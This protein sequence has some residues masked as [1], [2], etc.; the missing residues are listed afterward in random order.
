MAIAQALQHAA[1]HVV[2]VAEL[3]LIMLRRTRRPA[4]SEDDAAPQA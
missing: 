4:S 2:D 3:M 1:D